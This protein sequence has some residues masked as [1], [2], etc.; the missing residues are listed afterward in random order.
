MRKLFVCIAIALITCFFLTAQEETVNSNGYGSLRWGCSI[1]EFS[2]EY[3]DYVIMRKSD[4][5]FYHSEVFDL[6]FDQYIENGVTIISDTYNNNII[7]NSCK[8]FFF[9]NDQL[10]KVG[11]FYNGIRPNQFNTL[12]ELI[13]DNYGIFDK[14]ILEEK[15]IIW[16]M[17]EIINF[18]YR[19]VSAELIV[20]LKTSINNANNDSYAL[21]LY[22]NPI[23][24]DHINKILINQE[25]NKFKL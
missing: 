22:Y 2:I 5:N 13:K 24:E 25:K 3:P 20:I 16:G 4:W 15:E 11:V 23:L 21:A 8:I 10:Y 7:H 18:A 14:D 17:K 9:Y 12:K 6:N 19:F 1:S